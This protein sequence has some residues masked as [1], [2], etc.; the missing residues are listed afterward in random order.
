M[1]FHEEREMRRRLVELVVLLSVAL[2]AGPLGAAMWQWSTTAANNA[3]ADPS[4]NWAEGMAP[5]AVNDSARAMMAILA[6]WRND[7]SGKLVTGGS[8]TVLTL[9]TSQAFSSTTA[10]DG[11]TVSFTMHTTSGLNPTLSVDSVGSAQIVVDG[12]AGGTAPPVG[13]MVS[14]AVYSAVYQQSTNTWRMR[15]FYAGAYDIPLGGLLASTVSTPPNGNFILPAGQCIST[16]TYAAYWASI[17]SPASGGCPGGQFAVI[18]L[19]GRTLSALDNLNGSAANRLTSSSG[20]CGTAMTSMGAVCANGVEGRAITLAQLPTGIT[21][22]NASQAISVTSTNYL[23]GN[24]TTNTGSSPGGGTQLT[25][26]DPGSG[27]LIIKQ[28]SSGTNSISVTSNNTSGATTPTV[29]PV[30]GVYYFLRVL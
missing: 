23:L 1:G 18:D 2:G 6:N 25:A 19:R 10:A 22:V 21:S 26:S 17:G 30:V 15:N 14:G 5:S 27:A 9:T 12:V 8:S 16:T 11:A 20:G 29:Q 13:S 3:T 7:T 28:P 4:I 24:T